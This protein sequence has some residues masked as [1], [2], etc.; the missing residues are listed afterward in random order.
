M[1]RM[2]MEILKKRVSIELGILI[3]FFLCYVLVSYALGY[4][5]GWQN[6]FEIA[7][8]LT[9]LTNAEIIGCFG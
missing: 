4:S 2:I 3:V 5:I 8:N 7:E 9:A 6:G 1:I